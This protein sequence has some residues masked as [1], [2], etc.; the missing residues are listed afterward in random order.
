MFDTFDLH[1]QSLLYHAVNDNQ[2]FQSAPRPADGS[3]KRDLDMQY[4]IER[5]RL[6]KP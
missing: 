2:A 3:G 1:S 5:P 4:D 6:E